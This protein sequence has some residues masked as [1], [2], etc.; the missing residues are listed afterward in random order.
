MA[1]KSVY[2]T[3]DVI[4]QNQTVLLGWDGG[5]EDDNAYP[6]VSRGS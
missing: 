5:V 2:N 1:N 3:G 6:P 4:T